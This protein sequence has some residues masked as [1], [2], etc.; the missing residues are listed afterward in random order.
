MDNAFYLLAARQRNNDGQSGTGWRAARRPIRS[1][2]EETTDAEFVSHF[3]LTK[4]LFSDL[5]DVLRP[6]LKEQHRSTDLDQATK[7]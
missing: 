2:L 4:A 1:V 7:V 5:A 3:R 6:L